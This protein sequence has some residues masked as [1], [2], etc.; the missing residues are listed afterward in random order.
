LI[1]FNAGLSARTKA[2]AAI[3]LG[4]ADKALSDGAD[5]ELQLLSAAC[6]IRAAIQK[7]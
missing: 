4:E 3:V 1:I 7:G 6:K 2:T 5:E